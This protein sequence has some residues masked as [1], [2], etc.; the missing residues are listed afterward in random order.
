M[1]H[2]VTNPSS[3]DTLLTKVKVFLDLIKFEH[4]I[5]ALPFAYLGV[6][7]AAGGLP[8]FRQFFW[9]TVA[10]A[11]ARTFAFAVNRLADRHFDA[12]NPR[13]A[14]RPSVTGRLSPQLILTFA[15]LSLV[16]LAISAALLSPLAL[17]L[18]PGALVFLVGY[19]YSK[20]LRHSVTGYWDSPMD[21]RLS[22]AGSLC[23]AAFL[24]R[25]IYPLGC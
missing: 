7:L 25:M 13:T 4:T 16:L 17:I 15:V 2:V 3:N 12:T 8:T 9:V 18:F 19:S 11:S 23:A 5:F 1:T 6:V 10:M 14:N 21:W 22:V 20:R 24:L